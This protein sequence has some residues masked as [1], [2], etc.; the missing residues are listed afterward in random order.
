M[1]FA[2]GKLF[3]FVFNPVFMG[4]LFLFGLLIWMSLKRLWR[5]TLA[6]GFVFVW[7]WLWSTPWLY[8][9]LGGGLES[10]YPP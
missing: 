9:R 1:M 2:L 7:F 4:L 5:V 6:V 10:P 3:N 8:S